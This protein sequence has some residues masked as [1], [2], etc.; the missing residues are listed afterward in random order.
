QAPVIFVVENNGWALSLPTEKQTRAE[1]LCDRAKGYGIAGVRVDGNDADAVAAVI[2]DAADRARSGGG[3]T[4]V[5][6]ETYRIE[7]NS[8][9]D[10][11]RLYRSQEEV[12]D[13]ITKR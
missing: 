10:D 4:F 8:T 2:G 3:A 9:T 7:A 6:I 12:E 13:W 5:E 11:P 1:H